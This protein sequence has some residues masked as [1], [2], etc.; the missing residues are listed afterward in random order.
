MA[1][2]DRDVQEREERWQRRLE[3]RVEGQ[4]GG[5]HFVADGRGTVAV[6]EPEIGFEQINDRQI[7]DGLAIGYGPRFQACPGGDRCR[8]IPS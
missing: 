5:R 8:V 6:V 2:F 7:G 4:E 1:V 3:G